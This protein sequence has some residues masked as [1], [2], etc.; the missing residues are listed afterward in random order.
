MGEGGPAESGRL[1]SFPSPKKFKAGSPMKKAKDTNEN[2]KEQISVMEAK[3]AEAAAQ[4]PAE[5]LIVPYDNG[6]GQSGT[7]ENPFFS[8][9]S[10]LLGCYIKAVNT[11]NG[12]SGEKEMDADSVDELR[13]KFKIAK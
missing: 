3:L 8:A 9:Y 6:G 12:L 11:L 13:K 7:R 4:L 5:D 1:Q 2:L 10:K